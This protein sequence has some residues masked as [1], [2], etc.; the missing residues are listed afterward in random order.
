M[1][2]MLPLALAGAIVA[3]PAFAA[4]QG[5]QQTG[6]V[7]AYEGP[8]TGQVEEQHQDQQ[9]GAMTDLEAGPQAAL[10]YDFVRNIQEQ[11]QQQGYDIGEADGQWSEQTASA[12][13]QFQQDNNIEPSGQIGLETLAALGVGDDIQAAGV[14]EDDQQFG[15]PGD[16]QPSAEPGI[17]ESPGLEQDMNEPAPG[18][19]SP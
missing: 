16:D 19:G 15:Q 2:S 13:Q 18:G 17:G 3:S 14:P 1:K 9:Q 8:Q 5:G 7:G 4:G 12:L 6:T 10:D 11:L